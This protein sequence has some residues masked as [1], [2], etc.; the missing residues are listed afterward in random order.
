MHKGR[1]FPFQLFCVFASPHFSPLSF[2]HSYAFPVP[3]GGLFFHA[4]CLS[5]FAHTKHKHTHAETLQYTA[6]KQ[7]HH[8]AGE[9]GRPPTNTQMATGARVSHTDSDTLSLTHHYVR[10]FCAMI[11]RTALEVNFARARHT[12]TNTHTERNTP[13]VEKRPRPLPP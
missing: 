9:G 1:R 4:L 5:C 13:R 12:H 3:S 10:G 7:V 11:F 8:T 2:S 6:P